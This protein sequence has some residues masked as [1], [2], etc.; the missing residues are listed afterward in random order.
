MYIHE[1]LNIIPQQGFESL[2]PL[3]SEDLHVH[4]THSSADLSDRMGC[5]NVKKYTSINVD[6]DRGEHLVNNNHQIILEPTF[7]FGRKKAYNY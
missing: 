7:K 5:L 3:N 6:R 2:F 1:S 4:W